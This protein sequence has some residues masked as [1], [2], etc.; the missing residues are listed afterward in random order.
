MGTKK[1]II[2]FY[3]TFQERTGNNTYTHEALQL[4]YKL[5]NEF[6]LVFVVNIIL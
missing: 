2:Y 3:F 5:D 1:T 4:K 6:E